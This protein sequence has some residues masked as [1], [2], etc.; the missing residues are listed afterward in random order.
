MELKVI[1]GQNVLRFKVKIRETRV[2][3]T[4]WDK[5]DILASSRESSV[6]TDFFLERKNN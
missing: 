3:Q 4:R 1:F 2:S 6:L 5:F